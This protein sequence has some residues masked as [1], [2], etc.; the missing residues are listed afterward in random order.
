MQLHFQEIR[1]G[2][3]EQELTQKDQFDTDKVPLT[4][5]LVRESLQ[6]VM[7]AREPGFDQSLRVRIT[8]HNS[9]VA[10]REFWRDIFSGLDR[11]LEASDVAIGGYTLDSPSFLLIEDFGTT[12]LRG[13]TNERDEREFSDFWRRVGKSHKGSGKGGS[14][15]LGKLVFPVSSALRC[16]FGLTVRSDDS[17]RKPRLMGQ[18]ILSTHVL[19][20]KRYVP[21]G[22][23]CD[24]GEGGIQVP[25][26]DDATVERFRRAAGLARTNQPGLSI[27]I[28]FP[29][30]EITIEA[31]IPFVIEHYFFPILTGELVI[32]IGNETISA[33]TLEQLAKKYPAPVLKDGH[34]IAFIKALSL[35]READAPVIVPDDWDGSAGLEAVLGGALVQELRARYL[36]GDLLHFRLPIVCNSIADGRLTGSFDVYLQPAPAGASPVPLFIRNAITVP[37]E[38]SYFTNPQVFAAVVASDPV[39][40]SFLAGCRESRSHK[41]ERTRREADG[42]LADARIDIAKNPPQRPEAGPAC[43]QLGKHRRSGRAHFSFLNIPKPS[44]ARARKVP[45]SDQSTTSQPSG[46]N[47]S[48]VPDHPERWRLHRQR[49]GRECSRRSANVHQCPDGLRDRPRRCLQAL[50][51]QRFLA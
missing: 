22:F 50:R 21:H 40:S 13:A 15:G 29:R 4:A 33:E 20:G 44:V 49:S 23:F 32:E 39:V 7:D 36:R 3:V 48:P 51:S 12:G 14:W 38:A 30:K 8:F 46:T 9:V 16:F 18:A 11:H 27:A 17:S 43:R 24:L 34:M 47:A 6:N 28:P 31:L 42:P 35:A 5:T 1:P 2:D 26:G 10:D 45:N 19:D 37:N 41:L 25:A